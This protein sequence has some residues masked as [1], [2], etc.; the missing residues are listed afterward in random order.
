M[1]GMRVGKQ[2]IANI[3]KRSACAN[4][5]VVGVRAEVHQ[6][7]AVNQ[8]LRASTNILTAKFQR[9]LAQFAVAK[10]SRDAFFRSRTHIQNFHNFT[11]FLIYFFAYFYSQ[12]TAV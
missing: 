11:L 8:S 2:D 4:E 7:F 3:P 1:V 10:H 9:F 5:M 6:Q 12:K